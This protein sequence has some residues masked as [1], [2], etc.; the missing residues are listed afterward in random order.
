MGTHEY[1]FCESKEETEFRVETGFMHYGVIRLYLPSG[2]KSTGLFAAEIW[3]LT[4]T[5]TRWSSL[6][7][8]R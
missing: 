2:E 6:A 3:P 1:T 8:V 5:K 7:R 4:P